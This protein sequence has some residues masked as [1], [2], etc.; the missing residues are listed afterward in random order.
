MLA[1]SV[2]E[3]AP[4]LRI[5]EKVLDVPDW[6]GR[7]T[8]FHGD[9]H[10]A[11]VVVLDGRVSAIIDFDHVGTGDPACDMMIAWT[12]LSG[13]ERRAFRARLRIDDAT[14]ERGRGWVLD[15]GVRALAF[16]GPQD[17][18][19]KIGKRALDELTIDAGTPIEW[20]DATP[21]RRPMTN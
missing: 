4:L 1:G 12:M 20:L 11:N 3:T 18:L 6:S 13:A 17:L 16:T 15:L 9:L 19:T 7:P 21:A 14:W 10:P 2:A 5:W 8:W